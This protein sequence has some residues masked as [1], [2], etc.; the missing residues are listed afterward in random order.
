MESWWDRQSI[1]GLMLV[2]VKFTCCLLFNKWYFGMRKFIFSVK[3]N[4]NDIGVGLQ[5]ACCNLG[6]GTT[7]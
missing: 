1:Y 5:L 3:V 7:V 6:N 4:F 2:E